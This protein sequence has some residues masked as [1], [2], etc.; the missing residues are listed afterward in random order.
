M[1]K[2]LKLIN[3][4]RVELVI[5][6]KRKMQTVVWRMN[7]VHN[8]TSLAL[9]VKNSD[10]ITVGNHSYGELNVESYWNTDEKLTIGN[11][12]SIASDVKFILGGNHQINAFTTFPLKT[13]FVKDAPKDDAQTKGPIIIEDEVWIGCNAII[14]SGITIGKGA[15]VAAGSVVTKDVKPYTIVGGNPAKFIASRV[16]EDLIDDL[17]KAK[18]L[19]E[20]LKETLENID[21]FYKPLDREVLNNILEL[22]KKGIK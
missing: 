21:H 5:Y 17:L 6:L 9:T 18:I 19:N 15:I 13:K 10:M 4:F 11:F 2:Y 1:I 8:S 12:V 7:N 14:L 16:S 3:L 20:I 22:N